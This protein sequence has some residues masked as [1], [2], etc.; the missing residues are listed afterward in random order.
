MRFGFYKGWQPLKE[1]ISLLNTFNFARF[2]FLRPMVIYVD[3][4]LAL[5]ILAKER[6]AWRRLVPIALALQLLLLGGFNEEIRYRL[7]G[8]PSFEQ[9]YSEHLS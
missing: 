1:R 8:T 5:Q 3:F 9:F 4:A 2:H 7:A 6:T